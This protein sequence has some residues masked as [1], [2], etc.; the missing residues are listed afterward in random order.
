MM[1]TSPSPLNIYSDKRA[2]EAGFMLAKQPCKHGML[3][4]PCKWCAKE[5]ALKGG[6]A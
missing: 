5:R 4:L 1:V 6:G 3:H 2:R